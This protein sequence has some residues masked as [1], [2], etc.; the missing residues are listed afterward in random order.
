MNGLPDEIRNKI[1]K[2]KHQI[3]YKS[4]MDELLDRFTDLINDDLYFENK[5]QL[6]RYLRNNINDIDCII[7]N[8]G[9]RLEVLEYIKILNR[10]ILN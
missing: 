7:F 3:E 4:V 9:K 5:H 10:R 1:Y 6:L 2:Y 8:N